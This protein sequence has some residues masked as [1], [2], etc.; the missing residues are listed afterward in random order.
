MSEDMKPLTDFLVGQLRRE[1]HGECFNIAAKL[2]E[3]RDGFKAENER[4]RAKIERY[5]IAGVGLAKTLSRYHEKA[6][7]HTRASDC[8]GCITIEHWKN[9]MED[10][11]EKW[12]K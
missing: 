2:L 8:E 3:Q 10:G 11:G 4:M 12:A 5:E 9:A 1:G 7:F 6:E